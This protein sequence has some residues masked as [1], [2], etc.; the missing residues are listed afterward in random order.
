MILEGLADAADA[1]DYSDHWSEQ[2]VHDLV[3]FSSQHAS[4]SFDEQ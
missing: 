2:D 3:A 4:N 1:L